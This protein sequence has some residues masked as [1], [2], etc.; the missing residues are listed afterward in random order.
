[1][2]EPSP[3]HRILRVSEDSS[4]L[5][6]HWDDGRED[7]LGYFWLRDHARDAASFDAATQQR[8]LYTAGL[9]SD[10]R[11]VSLAVHERGDGM[12]VGWGDG[13]LAVYPADRLRTLAEPRLHRR[14]GPST[15]LWSSAP[16]LTWR[17]FDEAMA[18]P[19]RLV[20]EVAR[21]G[22]AAVADCPR[23]S[24]SVRQLASCF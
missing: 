1:M 6:V 19:Q 2:R 10:I 14:P 16:S 13:A 12:T 15:I 9:R 17:R 8:E 3:Q 4:E 21:L 7:R 22:F 20:A 11:P 23:G 24:D 18:S 5:I